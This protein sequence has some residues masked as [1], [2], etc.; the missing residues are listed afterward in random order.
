MFRTSSKLKTAAARHEPATSGWLKFASLAD[1]RL[2]EQ[3]ALHP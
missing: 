1:P 2:R 3:R